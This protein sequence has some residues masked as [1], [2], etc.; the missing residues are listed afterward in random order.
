MG[1][2]RRDISSR[3]EQYE[4]KRRG[5]KA[6]VSTG[7]HS[8]REQTGALWGKKCKSVRSCQVSLIPFLERARPL[9]EP[10]PSVRRGVL[11]TEAPRCPQARSGAPSPSLGASQH[12]SKS[13][14]TTRGGGMGGVASTRPSP[15][16]TESPS[17]CHSTLRAV[18]GPQH[19]PHITNMAD[20]MWLNKTEPDSDSTWGPSCYSAHD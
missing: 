10:G 3:R 19:L 4:Q 7:T 17:V 20:A 5:Q 12:D 9:R 18:Q 8:A 16:Q 13:A 1:I 11:A 6:Q 14:L 2:C 15:H